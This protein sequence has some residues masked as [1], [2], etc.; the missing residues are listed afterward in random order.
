MPTTLLHPPLIMG[1]TAGVLGLLYVLLSAL[2]VSNRSKNKVLLGDGG[3]DGAPSLLT[4]IRTHANFA[5]YVPFALILIGYQETV[6]GQTIMVKALCGA[7]IVARV[8]HPMGMFA[9][10]TNP[11]RA[12]GFVLTLTVIAVAAGGDI[13]TILG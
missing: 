11:M 2:V 7:L 13:L 9:G 3:D 4:A 12:G 5:E 1:L 10:G 6:A 8:L